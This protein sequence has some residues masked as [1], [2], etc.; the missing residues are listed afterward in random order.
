MS[1]TCAGCGASVMS[2]AV[3]EVRKDEGKLCIVVSEEGIICDE[4]SECLLY[5]RVFELRRFR[6]DLCSE[7]CQP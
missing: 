7:E 2:V 6:D 3:A 1:L 4:L 5:G